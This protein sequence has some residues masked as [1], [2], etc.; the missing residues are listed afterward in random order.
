MNLADTRQPR[1]TPPKKRALKRQL[2]LNEAARQMNERGAGAISLAE[3][4]EVA[5]LSRNAMYYYCTDRADLAFQCYLRSCEAAT[6]CMAL[7][8]E[9][10]DNAVSRIQAYVRRMLDFD[11]PEF[12][13]LYDPDFLPEPQRST[14]FELNRR[15]VEGLQTLI[16]DGIRE[17]LLRSVHTEI[18]AQMLLGMINWTLL[19]N[20][21]LGQKD[22]RPRRRNITKVIIDLFLNGASARPE[23]AFE[24]KLDATSLM[25]RPF[26]AFDRVQATQEKMAQ[27]IDAAARLFNRRGLDGVSLDEISASV[28]ATKGAVY[29]YFND[30]MDLITRCYDR[31]FELY[32]LFLDVAKGQAGSGFERAMAVLHLNSQAQ[33]CQSAPLV[34]QPGLFSLSEVHRLRF[35]ERARDIWDRSTA[36]VSEG[37]EDGTY[38]RCDAA[39]VAHVS[40]GAFL[41]LH[42]WLPDDYPM[43][44]IEIADTQC[45]I[46][47][48]GVSCKRQ[49][50]A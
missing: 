8:L 29:H 6:E 28:G 23:V 9:E 41:W 4:A 12:A 45:G 34:L 27:L 22:S 44:P 7:A 30:K 42:K 25:A 43:S 20:N 16:E 39:S 50:S 15:N 47:A 38:R 19:T 48:E 14:I 35:V 21:W 24:C 46:F 1:A 31:A 3:I 32:A 33:R 18:A 36:M 10:G 2:L 5:G 40:A 17:R 13:A 26:N 37:I 49:I 11:Q